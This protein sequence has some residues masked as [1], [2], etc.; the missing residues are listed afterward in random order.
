MR[1]R[2]LSR[3]LLARDLTRD[4]MNDGSARSTFRVARAH[5]V[6][7][8]AL[9]DVVVSS[10]SPRR[11][12]SIARLTEEQ[13]APRSAPAAV[14]RVVP[15]RRDAPRA[16]DMSPLKPETCKRRPDPKKGGGTGRAFVPWCDRR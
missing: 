4:R 11:S 16:L 15:A 9:P 3:E 2:N 8:D 5:R 10:P 6:L 7:A 13:E 12:L 1:R 14:Q